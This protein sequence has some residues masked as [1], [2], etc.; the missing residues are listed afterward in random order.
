MRHTVPYGIIWHAALLHRSVW[1]FMSDP[2]RH[3]P[4]WSPIT[5]EKSQGRKIILRLPNT[6]VCTLHSSTGGRCPECAEVVSD[7]RTINSL[8]KTSRMPKQQR[9]KKIHKLHFL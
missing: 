5:K 9:T 6:N 4:Q 3:F 8:G 1:S 2:L 7:L